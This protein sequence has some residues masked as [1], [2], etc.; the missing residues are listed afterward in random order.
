MNDIETKTSEWRLDLQKA[1]GALMAIADDYA[2]PR[3]KMDDY[4]FLSRKD[5]RDLLIGVMNDYLCKI[6]EE[7]DKWEKD[8]YPA[9]ER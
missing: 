6:I 1:N 8:L 3:S 9:Q 4:Y 7:M 2:K 5:H